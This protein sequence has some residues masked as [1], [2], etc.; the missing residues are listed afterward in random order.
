M[1]PDP[2]PA[3][4]EPD[5]RACPDLTGYLPAIELQHRRLDLLTV[6]IG[7]QPDR[8]PTT[9]LGRDPDS[10]FRR[11]DLPQQLER[12]LLDN[13]VISEGPPILELLAGKGKNL[14][15]GRDSL[16]V[17]DLRLDILDRVALLD[18]ERD[19]LAGRSLDENL[20]RQGVC[21]RH[22][23]KRDAGNQQKQGQ[24]VHRSH[25]RRVAHAL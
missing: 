23:D 13:V 19:R 22:G 11:V 24:T 2:C 14:A 1:D 21:D 6:E 17:F 18:F 15:I 5:R 4:V 12:R 8:R 7:G 25:A 16:L 9:N 10:R 20:H 3:Q